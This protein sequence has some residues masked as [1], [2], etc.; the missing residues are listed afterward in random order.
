[1]LHVRDDWKRICL[2]GMVGV[3][4]LLLQRPLLSSL[5]LSIT[6]LLS[7]HHS[8]LLS[9]SI[10]PL[11]SL[12]PSLLSSSLLSLSITPLLLQRPLLSRPIIVYF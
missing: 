1:M 10:T 8:P 4:T 2:Y 5:S 11:L 12:S 6:P 9:L 3:W 7:L